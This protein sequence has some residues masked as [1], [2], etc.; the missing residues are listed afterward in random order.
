[1]KQRVS[2][3]VSVICLVL[4]G[5]FFYLYINKGFYALDSKYKNNAVRDVV[6]VADTEDPLNRKIDFEK[7]RAINKD[8]AGWI[9]VPGTTIDYPIL[10][11]EED[12]TYLNRDIHKEYSP[13]GSIFSYSDTPRDFS[14][15][16]TILFGHNMLKLQM[17]GELRKFLNNDY[18][19]EHRKFYVYTD[20]KT[21]EFDIFSIFICEE[22]DEFFYS[23]RELGTA[24][25]FSFLSEVVGR[26]V[27]SDYNLGDTS[28]NLADT[29]MFSLVTCNGAEG[30][31]SRLV[32]N[33]VSTRQ[34]YII[35]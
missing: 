9:Y 5:I 7:L 4:G 13:L 16:H 23:G 15:A 21:L 35:N 25:Y 10:I 32:V 14:N 3:I 2:R 31:T 18:M 28:L 11:G 33:G 19:R 27:Y 1:M 34:K 17:F 26:N 29:E 30:T 24:D 6:I 20:R 22:T 8:V 12:E